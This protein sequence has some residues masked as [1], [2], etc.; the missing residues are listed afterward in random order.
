MSFETLRTQ[1]VFA[2]TNAQS[3]LDFLDQVGKALPEIAHPLLDS[4]IKVRDVA[5]ATFKAP[6]PG[7]QPLSERLTPRPLFLDLSALEAPVSDG[8]SLVPHSRSWPVYPVFRRTGQDASQVVW[9][10]TLEAQP[11]ICL[12]AASSEVLAELGAATNEGYELVPAGTE[13]LC[14]LKSL[15]DS[16][17]YRVFDRATA[18]ADET[19]S[20]LRQA[21]A[22]LEEL[23]EE[24]IDC[25]QGLPPAFVVSHLLRKRT[26]FGVSLSYRSHTNLMSS[27]ISGAGLIQKAAW[28]QLGEFMDGVAV[29]GTD[30][31]RASDK[32]WRDMPELTFK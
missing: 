3:Q 4:L 8:L 5:Y 29:R 24:L 13:K 31:A 19:Q 18:S 30:R 9:H 1:H 26:G 27:A 7:L 11:L 10:T 14:Y 25:Y 15:D 21:R 17:D 2:V 6:E 12:V 28:L 23:N 16:G 22:A 32:N 20:A